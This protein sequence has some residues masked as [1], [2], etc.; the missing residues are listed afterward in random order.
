MEQWGGVADNFKAYWSKAKPQHRREGQSLLNTV[1]LGCEGIQPST[2][3]P[4]DCRYFGLFVV[5]VGGLFC[6]F[7]SKW[8]AS[9]AITYW[10][11]FLEFKN[12][13]C[14][15]TLLKS[16][17]EGGKNALHLRNNAFDMNPLTD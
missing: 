10:V 17:G 16:S 12:P 8:A 11:T 15:Q 3:P 14:S 13:K 5:G 9:L 1:N 6:A 2:S 4:G 7:G